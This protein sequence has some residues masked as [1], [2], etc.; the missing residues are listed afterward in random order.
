MMVLYA[1]RRN[2]HVNLMIPRIRSLIDKITM[3]MA[4]EWPSTRQQDNSG[5]LNPKA[6]IPCGSSREE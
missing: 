5:G 3:A 4:I 1:K 6:L 2:I